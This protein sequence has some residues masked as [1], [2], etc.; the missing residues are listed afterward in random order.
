ML[1][2]VTVRNQPNLAKNF[3]AFDR[4][5]HL[6]FVRLIVKMARGKQSQRKETAHSK[7][8]KN[9]KSFS[10]DTKKV[11][12]KAVPN[13]VSV[14]GN[15]YADE[16][17]ALKKNEEHFDDLLTGDF[18]GDLDEALSTLYE[19]TSKLCEKYAWAI[20][21]DR[22]LRILESFSPIVEVGAGKGYWASLLRQRGVDILA[23]DKF[24]YTKNIKANS[25]K[26]NKSDVPTFTEVLR[27]GPEVLQ[28]PETTHRNLF[29]CYPDEAESMA[30]DCLDQVLQHHTAEYILHVGENISTGTVLGPPTAPFGRTSSADFQ[31]FIL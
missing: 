20:P 11:E 25:D 4:T 22:V 5:V 14:Q 23:Y 28:Q 27:G 31:V 19:K 10:K 17:N 1:F 16:F 30:A 3:I 29:L 6:D 12:G 7:E 9:P 15:P 2:W 18:E 24:C 21:D 8:G 13:I 26:K